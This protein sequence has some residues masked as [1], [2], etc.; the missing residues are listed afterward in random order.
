MKIAYLIT[1]YLDPS[2]L[3]RLCEAIL[4]HEKDDVAEVFLHIDQ[5]VDIAPFRSIL[6]DVVGVHFCRNRFYINWGG[7]NQVLS[8]RELLCCALDSKTKF[9]RFVCISATDYP[10]W[11]NRKIMQYFKN[12]PKL[13]LVGGYDLTD[14]KCM[15]QKKKVIYYHFFRD[16]PVPIR[17][18]RF[19]S[20]GSRTILRLLGF[21]RKPIV[22][23]GNGKKGH[24]FTGSDYWAITRGCAQ[25]V[26]EGLQ[27]GS[28]YIKRLK[29]TYIPSEIIVNTIVYNSPYRDNAHPL[30]K[31][32]EENMSPMPGLDLLTPLQIIDYS[33]AIK[34]WTLKDYNQLVNSGKMFCR[35]T[36][37]G[38][39]DTLINKIDSDLRKEV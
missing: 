24:I 7:F 36:L 1:A 17:V 4:Y 34:V 10:L 35:K 18:R 13:E 2:Q 11:S 15:W 5:K 25:T 21:R 31:I 38:V 19:F 26:F 39:S 6:K 28:P 23:L 12:N 8:Q 22:H 37:S 33:S 3:K 14:S 16:L 20:Y 9:D 29:N 27:N 32:D 30:L